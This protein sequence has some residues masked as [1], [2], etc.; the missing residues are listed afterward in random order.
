MSAPLPPHPPPTLR[1]RYYCTA[2]TGKGFY[3]ELT[4]RGGSVPPRREDAFRGQ[5]LR[6]A[7]ALVDRWQDSA[8]DVPDAVRRTREAVSRARGVGRGDHSFFFPYFLVYSFF[9]RLWDRLLG[10]N[11]R[12]RSNREESDLV[13]N[14]SAKNI[15]LKYCSLRP[16][17]VFLRVWSFLLFVR[18][19][20]Q[21]LQY[22][23]IIIICFWMMPKYLNK[24]IRPW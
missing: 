6:E 19:S 24:I 2:I 23:C 13:C 21:R 1:Q 22:N 3:L 16:S 5:R 17:L 12:Y 8:P 4:Q 7:A 20:A 10:C 15:A 14:L 11:G 9:S 18:V